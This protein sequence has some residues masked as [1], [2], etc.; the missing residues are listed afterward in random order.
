M[1]TTTKHCP[2][3]A[4]DLP[5]S[6]FGPDRSRPPLFLQGRCRPC[7][8]QA[9][10]ASRKPATWEADLA[11]IVARVEALPVAE[12]HRDS[13]GCREIRLL[14]QPALRGRGRVRQEYP[15]SPGEARR[16]WF[17]MIVGRFV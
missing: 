3:C 9:K 1:T 17:D 4:C 8:T 7:T 13:S 10:R 14:A 11:V 6:S 16:N 12:V 15:A 5:H 2:S